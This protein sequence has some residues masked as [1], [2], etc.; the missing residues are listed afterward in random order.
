MSIIMYDLIKTNGGIQMNEMREMMRKF[1]IAV[2]HIDEVYCS[3]TAQ[4]GVKE[5]ELWLLYAL[6]DEKAYLIKKYF[7]KQK[8]I[9]A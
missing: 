1:A 7:Q 6:D 3:D 2:N 5:S 8:E 4:I 9:Q